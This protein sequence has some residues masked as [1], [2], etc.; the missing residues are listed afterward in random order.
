VSITL[1]TP[2]ADDELALGF[3]YG[4]GLL[5]DRAALRSVAHV[6]PERN[7]LAIETAEPLDLSRLE[8][9]FY[10]T[11]SCGVCGKR[12]LDL[13]A[14]LAPPVTAAVRV[15]PDW[16]LGLPDRLAA[17]Q[18]T[19]AQTGS[20]HATGLFAADGELLVSYEDVGRHNAVDKVI[21][22]SFL[23]GLLP[24]AGHV[25][26]VSGRASFEIMQKAAVAGIP[27]VAALSGPSTLA[28]DLAERAGITLV[29]FL[30]GDRFN[31][32]SHAERIAAPG[33]AVY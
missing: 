28:A 10:A 30:R 25:M 26:L 16:L 8:R 9:H 14:T 2:G 5:R 15:T 24:L 1:R 6:G 13:V 4:E 22:H 17:A 19:F 21:G 23:A 18:A 20:L 12:A 7:I 33:Q 32:Y 27:V 31:V 11:S 3:L 29:G